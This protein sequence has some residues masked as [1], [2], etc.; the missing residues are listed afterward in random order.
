[1]LPRKLHPEISLSRSD[2]VCV[3]LFNPILLNEHKLIDNESDIYEC[4]NHT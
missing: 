2:T 3:S 4:F 1:M